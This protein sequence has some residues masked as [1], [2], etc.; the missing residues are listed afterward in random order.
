MGSAKKTLLEWQLSDHRG[1]QQASELRIPSSLSTS[2]LPDALPTPS[3]INQKRNMQ[4][5]QL[6]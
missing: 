2:Q 3:I 5:K 6:N 1:F 4:L